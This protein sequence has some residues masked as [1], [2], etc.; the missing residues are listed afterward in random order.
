M[1]RLVGMVEPIVEKVRFDVIMAQNSHHVIQTSVCLGRSVNI[2]MLPAIFSTA[3]QPCSAGDREAI[4]STS[5]LVAGTG[6]HR[7]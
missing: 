7:V 4:R 1:Y 6:S 2:S 5:F 3:A